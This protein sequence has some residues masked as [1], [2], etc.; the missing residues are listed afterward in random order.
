MNDKMNNDYMTSW[1]EVMLYETL[2]HHYL[3]FIK[4][5]ELNFRKFEMGVL[6]VL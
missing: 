2:I 3:Y 1:N 5:F 4:T 6:G